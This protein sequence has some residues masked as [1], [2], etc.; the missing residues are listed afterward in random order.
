MYRCVPCVLGWGGGRERERGGGGVGSRRG[1]RHRHGTG[2][3][4]LRRDGTWRHDGIWTEAPGVLPL[5]FPPSSPSGVH[6]DPAR[7]PASQRSQSCA[8]V[9]TPSTCPPSGPR[10]RPS[11][12]P[13]SPP[14]PPGK[15]APSS[16]ED[17]EQSVTNT[18]AV[19]I[20]NRASGATTSRPLARDRRTLTLPSIPVPG[21]LISGTPQRRTRPPRHVPMSDRT[22]SRL[23]LLSG[24]LGATPTATQQIAPLSR[25]DPGGA[26]APRLP[27]FGT[28]K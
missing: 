23:G 3:C 13:N 8:S 27:K 6:R 28:T 7:T 12:Q 14:S 16:I 10:T 17:V 4:A 26:H 1:Q 11:A 22:A 15:Q 5:K 21:G 9:H 18:R 25:T 19:G 24:R 2:G 20:R